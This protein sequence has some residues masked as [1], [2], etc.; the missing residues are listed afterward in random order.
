MSVQLVE[1]LNVH[2]LKS[3]QPFTA[4]LEHE[5]MRQIVT[6]QMLQDKLVLHNECG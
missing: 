3:L 1:P 6:T 2:T 5:E 4:H